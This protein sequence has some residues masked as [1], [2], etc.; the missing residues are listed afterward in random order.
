MEQQSTDLRVEFKRLEKSVGEIKDTL[1]QVHGAIVGNELSGDG[2][3]AKRLK[4]AEEKLDALETRLISAE[5]KQIRYNIY[6][7]IMWVCIGGIAMAIFNYVV[8][9]F[10]KR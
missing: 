8:T 4:N 1:G 6:T 9:L 10:L 5:K 3:M 7:I 2:G